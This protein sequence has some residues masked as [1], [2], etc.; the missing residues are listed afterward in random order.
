MPPPPTYPRTDLSSSVVFITGGEDTGSSLL[1]I[2]LCIFNHFTPD[3]FLR[4]HQ[5]YILRTLSSLPLPP[6]SSSL[7]SLSPASSG[8]GEAC[9]WRFA[10]QGCRLILAARRLDLLQALARELTRY[11]PTCTVHCVP[12]DVRCRDAL[13]A[14]PHELPEDLRDVDILVNNAG[15]ALGIA[16]TDTV[17]FED[18]HAMLE[19]NLTSA[20]ILTRL[21]APGMKVGYIQPYIPYN[22]TTIQPVLQPYH[23]NSR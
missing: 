20:M 6:P 18:L 16:S 2:P 22:H 10:E 14:L 7:R 19:T 5:K 1:H 11:Y 13:M 3:H 8:I 21:F 12:L 17:S 15:C 23:H 4:I 9:A